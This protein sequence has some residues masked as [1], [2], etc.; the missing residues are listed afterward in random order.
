V[1]GS[2]GEKPVAANY[3]IDVIRFI[4]IFM[5]ILLHSSGFP[6]RFLNPAVTGM[7]VVNWLSTT[8]YAAA[9]LLGVPLFVMLT[10][11]LLLDPNREEEPLKVFYKK[12]LD[13]I[14][15]PFIFWTVIYFAW[16]FGVL[17]QPLTLMSMV[18]GLASGAYTH[19]W[20]LYLLMGLYALTPVLRVLV[21]HLDRKL[22]LYL[23]IIWFAGTTLTPAIH[24]FLPQLNYYP[25]PFILIDWVGYYLLGLYLLQTSM[26]KLRALLLMLGGLLGTVASSWLLTSILGEQYTGFF[27]SYVSPTIIL[28][29]AAL[30]FALISLD[31]NSLGNR[32][33]LGG[34]IQWVS[35]NTLPIYLIHMIILVTLVS[36]GV[37]G[38]WVNSITDIVLIDVPIFAVIVFTL[39]AGIVFVLKKVPGLAK[40]LG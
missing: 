23:L 33:I 34:I 16:T 20:Y 2:L 40:L 5:V 35:Q 22:Y 9:G 1:V 11:V 3:T 30:F 24:V 28:A 27:H 8:T 18:Q 14:G 31:F 26:P 4:A 7:D 6:Y 38:F 21:R 39:S 37:F 25:Y 10:G 13:R 32:K 29:S 15:L 19:L 17:G 36:N 12:R